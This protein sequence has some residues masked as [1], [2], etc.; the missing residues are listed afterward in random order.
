MIFGLRH[1]E[2][3]KLGPQRVTAKG[4]A[5]VQPP[6]LAESSTTA[7]LNVLGF[8]NALIAIKIL[9]IKFNVGLRACPTFAIHSISLEEFS[10]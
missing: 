1:Y 2:T 3:A 10:S 4:S 5:V 7:E 9:N 8:E 6:L